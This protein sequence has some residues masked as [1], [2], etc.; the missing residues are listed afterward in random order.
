MNQN[1]EFKQDFHKRE[2]DPRL[3]IRACQYYY[4]QLDMHLKNVQHLSQETIKFYV[5]RLLEAT[6]F[7]ENYANQIYEDLSDEEKN[8]LNIEEIKRN[9]HL[10]EDSAGKPL[11]PQ[12]VHDV[13]TCIETANKRYE[14]IREDAKERLNK[15]D[16]SQI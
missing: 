4:R 2:C 10:Y 16:G 3:I 11:K 14:K 7:L 6:M 12:A 13:D 5:D 15:E 9:M 1:E 8:I